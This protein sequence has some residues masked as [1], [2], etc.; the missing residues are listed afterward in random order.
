MGW[1]KFDFRTNTP[2]LPDN[3]LNNLNYIR[4][5]PNGKTAILDHDAILMKLERMACEVCESHMSSGQLI[6]CGLN[7]RGYYVAVLLSEKIKQILPVLEITLLNAKIEGEGVSFDKAVDFTEK[8]VL[9]VDDVINTGY[10]IMQVQ[11]KIFSEKPITIGTAFLAKREHRNFPVKADYV[12][13]S[14]ATTLRE[15]VFFDNSEPTNLNVFLS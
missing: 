4:C 8:H 5:M 15:H 7:S 6:I 12:G 11:S 14:L 1:K 9:L 3:L 2:L 13:I 10:T